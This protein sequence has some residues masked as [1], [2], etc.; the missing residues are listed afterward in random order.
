MRTVCTARCKDKQAGAVA[1]YEQGY[2]DNINNL[3]RE[4]EKVAVMPGPSGVCAAE[5]IPFSSPISKNQIFKKKSV[6]DIRGVFRGGS[7]SFKRKYSTTDAKPIQLRN[8]DILL[9][10]SGNNGQ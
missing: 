1:V 9:P 8:N 7:K 6:A 3:T 4:V 10:S 2:S 5:C